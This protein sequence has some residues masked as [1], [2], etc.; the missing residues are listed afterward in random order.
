VSID[1][2]DIDATEV[3]AASY[4]AFLDTRPDP[5]NQPPYCGWN[6]TY[7]PIEDREQGC[8]GAF[9]VTTFP[10]RPISCIDW[11][12]AY[13]Y[14]A[15]A[16][17]HLCGRIGGG[18]LTQDNAGDPDLS[19]WYRACS[20]AGTRDYP[21]GDTFIDA[22]CNTQGA[23][24]GGVPTDVATLTDCEGGYPGIFDMSGNVQEW[25]DSCTTGVDPNDPADDGCL[26][27]GGAYWTDDS[28]SRCD[29]LVY[30]P[31]RSTAIKDY[32]FRCCGPTG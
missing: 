4:Q 32:G 3:T 8:D 25:E 19:E 18:L 13:A 2:Y 23:G 15:W 27:R 17:R 31:P 29:S 7:Q 14:C 5:A 30:G 26:V 10:N 12:D 6:Q 21:Y 11:C 16:K 28:D 9:D 22:N 20:A 24:F 1:A